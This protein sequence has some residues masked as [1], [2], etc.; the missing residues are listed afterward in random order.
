MK[1]VIATDSFK[2]SISSVEGSLAIA[3]GVR[4]VVPHAEVVTFPLADGGEGTV[5]ALIHATAG[6]FISLDVTG[7]MQEK[8]NAVYGIMDDSKTAVIEVAQACGLSLIPTDQRNPLLSTS[9][10]VGELISDAIG[11]GCLHFIIGLGGSATN[12]AGVGMLQA[13]GYRF[14]NREGKEIGFGGKWLRDIRSIDESKANPTLAQCTFRVA[15]DVNNPLYGENGAAYVFG[16]QKGADSQMVRELDQG[17][18]HFAEVV[19]N[20]RGKDIQ[21]IAGAGAAGGLGGAFAGLLHGSLES[22]IE[23]ILDANKFKE[24]LKGTDLI[25]TGEGKLDEQTLMGKALSGLAH[26][27]QEHSIPMIVLA[28]SVPVNTSY[29]HSVGI[30]SCF[31]VV[32]QPMSLEQAMDVRTTGTC[33]QFTTNQLLRLI[34]AFQT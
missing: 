32:N 14:L 12:D 9:Y 25:I 28:G 17:L 22:G 23:L 34:R 21:Q 31:S 18:K 6:S 26:H 5:Q 4:D 8:V 30:T 20:E 27:A 16:P 10:G 3:A 33:L 19:L 24:T 11:R 7:P 13:L 15:C 2:G 29:M 1:I